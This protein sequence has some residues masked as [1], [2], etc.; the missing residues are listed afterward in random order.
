L[1]DEVTLRL[2]KRTA[3][4]ALDVLAHELISGPRR[5]RRLNLT[6]ADLR[7]ANVGNARFSTPPDMKGCDLSRAFLDGG[8]LSGGQGCRSG[9]A[10][11]LSWP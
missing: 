1:E 9:V 2:R 4:S 5:D 7:L 3:Q 6:Y 10:A 11:A 8:D